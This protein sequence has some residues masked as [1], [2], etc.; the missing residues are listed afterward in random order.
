MFN[1]EATKSSAGFIGSE[2]I[3]A[4]SPPPLRVMTIYKNETVDLK[5]GAE[6]RIPN[7]TIPHVQEHAPA[8][9]SLDAQRR[10]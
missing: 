2:V 5:T 4:P 7:S 9:E 3:T 8:Q 10:R 1:A 6:A